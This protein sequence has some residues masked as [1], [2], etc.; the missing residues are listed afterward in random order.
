MSGNLDPAS[1]AYA[2]ATP[3]QNLLA[4]FAR[5]PTAANLVLAIMLVAGLAGL[6]RMNTQFFPDFG[7]DIVTVSVTWQGA[8][9][10]DVDLSIV[11]AIET[12]VRFLD[13]VKRVR[14]TAREGVASIVVEFEQGADM[15]AAL[16]NVDAA[17]AQATTLPEDAETPEVARVVRYDTIARLAL[18]GPYSESAL[19]NF[20]KRLRDE[21]IA[22]GI[23]RVTF[24]GMR[25]PE[26]WVE[27]DPLKLRALDVTLDDMAQAIARSSQD[28]PSGEA[29]GGARQIRSLGLAET[30]EA[31]AAIELKSDDRGAKARIADV[32]IVHET[33]DEEQVT[34]LRRGLPAI[35]LE[36]KRATTADSLAT[37]KILDDYLARVGPTLPPDLTLEKYGVESDLVEERIWLLVKNGV[38]GLVIVVAVLFLFLNARVAFWVGMGIPAS[39]M[40]ALAGMW[41]SGQSINMISLFGLILVLGIVVDDA[42]VVG[43]HAEALKRRGLSALEAAERGAMRMAAPVTSSTLTTIAAFLPLFVI[44]DIIGTIIAAIPMAVCAALIASWI[45]CFLALPGHMKMALQAPQSANG[46]LRARFNRRFD[47]FREGPFRRWVDLA[48]A[49][50]YVTVAMALAAFVMS[51]G[52][53]A[54][55]RVAFNFFPSVE[56]DIAF[57]N[58]RLAP[59][60]GRAATEAALAE[61][62]RAAY[63][64]EQELGYLESALVVQALATVGETTGREQGTGASGDEIGSVFLELV[65]AD[66]RDV[67]TPEF[68]AAWE[69]AIRPIAGLESLTLTPAQGGPPG[70]E[71]DVRL[72][73]GDPAVLK[74]AAAEVRALLASYTGVTAIEDDL[75]YGKVE[76]V[77]EL[78]DKGRALGFTTESV[79]RQVRDAYAGAVAK[80]FARGDDE[81]LVRVR[82]NQDVLA[83]QSVRDLY[84]RAPGG[85]ETPLSEVVA[86]REE[87]GFAQI[88]REDGSRLVAVTAEI[89]ETQTTGGNV[90]A[91]LERDGVG[92]IAS[93]AGLTYRF[94]GKAEEQADTFKDM[95]VGA[96]I[97]VILMYIIL[98]WVFGSFARPFAVMAIIPFGFIGAMLG[99]WIMGF[100]L[101]ILSIFA[102]LGLAGILVNDS[103]V[104]ITTIDGRVADGEDLATATRE[105]AVDRVRAVLL[106]SLTTIG[107]LLPML[108]ETSLQARFLLPMAVTI[109]FGLL[110]ATLLVLFLV[111]SLVMIGRDF[112]N[113]GQGFRRFLN[114]TFAARTGMRSTPE[115]SEG[116]P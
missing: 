70:R 25:D 53:V 55:G 30:A 64:A 85:A 115:N 93:R 110:A 17:V 108:F 51:A 44:G 92:E 68:L 9:A 15:Q 48:L 7:I 39:L 101:T 62:E 8:S 3:P 72:S 69:A 94:A 12:E 111:P 61:V 19:R 37:A 77:M 5:H 54:G 66:S 27:A 114:W 23:D 22:S 113:L 56:A 14:S 41:L 18:S 106:T 42:I 50:R 109:V 20:A 90:L 81:V 86:F 80:R 4:R 88:R 96:I 95:G 75:P 6:W 83:E 40:A 35:E 84:L 13:E 47:A 2:E 38:G 116:A 63:R 49:W 107:G 57:A 43:E 100:D 1:A 28:A 34:A 91:A 58:L 46:G 16:A 11:Q 71:L 104:L 82:L 21:M 73:G 112:R 60:G 29:G 87:T 99:H 26:I 98:A 76:L 10:D 105:G 97:G 102:L 89:D 45:E 24:S 31:I 78:T 74:R 52:L 32:A 33:Y 65:P 103:I 79:A 36:V 67:R 59:G